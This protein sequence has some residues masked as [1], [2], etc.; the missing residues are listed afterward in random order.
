MSTSS[1]ERIQELFSGARELPAGERAAWLQQHTDGDAELLREVTDLLAHDL[2]EP[3]FETPQRLPTALAPIAPQPRDSATVELLLGLK[4]HRTTLIVLGLSIVVLMVVGMSTRSLMQQEITDSLREQLKTVRN[5]AAL[6]LQ[7][8]L[9][10][11][12]LVLSRAASDPELPHVAQALTELSSSV[13]DDALRR[14]AIQG[15]QDAARSMP[16]SAILRLDLAANRQDHDGW[17]LISRE[18]LLLASGELI[19]GEQRRN[20]P[21]DHI[22]PD[23]MPLV[24]RAFLGEGLF[25]PPRHNLAAQQTGA[26]PY[27][28]MLEPVRRSDGVVVAALAFILDPAGRFTSTLTE[29][30]MGTSGETYAFDADGL[31]LSNSLFEAQLTGLGLLPDGL[32][33]A[34]N[35]RVGDPEGNLL[36]G[37]QP[38]AL[39]RDFKLTA[40]VRRARDERAPGLDFEGYRDYRGVTVV[41]A[42]TWLDE[43]GFGLVT[44][45]DR[46]EAHAPLV[47]LTQ[48]F[49]IL[50]GLVAL[51]V[52]GVL[53]AVGKAAH[54]AS[55]ID[56]VLRLGQYQLVEVLGQGGMGTVYRAEHA[57]LQRSVA[58]KVVRRTRGDNENALRIEREVTMASRLT[59]ANTIEVY[60]CGH[61]ANGD[62]YYVM[63]YLDGLTVHEL[64]SGAG[65]LPAARVVHLLRQAVSSLREAHRMG[66]VHRDI[67]PANLMVCERGGIPD[68][69]KVLDF[70]LVKDI[71][72]D[73]IDEGVTRHLSGTPLYMA[74]E[75]L[76]NQPVDGRADLFALGATGFVMLTGRQAHAGTTPAEMAAAVLH[77]EPSSPGRYAPHPV[78]KE[79][80]ELIVAL[81]AP[82]RED[83][84]A[85]ADAVLKLLDQVSGPTWTE[86]DAHAFW[87]AQGARLRQAASTRRLA[88]QAEL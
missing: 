4:A 27:M 41:G 18:G 20:G 58:I 68:V 31:M 76:R 21:G 22:H 38:D 69:V 26:K 56:R 60:D 44:E 43:L 71:S 80:D 17:A 23:N 12:R 10:D 29:A 30:R 40:A 79:L 62:L 8:W 25:V 77:D 59:H 61:E 51:G 82:D 67:K 73:A 75:R 5:L 83:R 9:E 64:V 78:P 85:D 45:I 47:H 84:P 66:L 2:A 49:V 70:G 65:P 74:P 32:E 86:D 11:E 87:E 50:L 63:E 53:I 14:E 52:A 7:D 46:D 34:L 13:G 57:L 37:F 54:L 16:D 6:S 15:F 39:P 24:S 28:A 35:L 1:W 72:A 42:W 33:S 36:T 81:L 88:I 19:A 48:A 55:A 3:I